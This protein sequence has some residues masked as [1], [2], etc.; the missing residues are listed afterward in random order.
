MVNPK[1]QIAVVDDEVDLINRFCEA[2]SSEELNSIG[3]DDPSIALEYIRKHPSD[4]DMVITDWKMP[5][6]NGLEL[7]KKVD[8]IDNDIK[9]VLMSAYELQQDQLK[10]VKKD[11]YMKKPIHMAKLIETVKKELT[12][13]HYLKWDTDL[14]Y[15]ILFLF[16][17]SHN[18]TVGPRF[19]VWRFLS[20]LSLAI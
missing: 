9:V 6:M 8:E 5:K 14:R 11:D 13:V 3:F 19:V 1:K 4:I 2:L 18:R 17:S 16:Q 20:Q 7:I 12:Q 10:E 15:V